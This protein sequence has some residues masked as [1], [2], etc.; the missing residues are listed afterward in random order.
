MW[1]LLRIPKHH[2]LGAETKPTIKEDALLSQ[3]GFSPGATRLSFVEPFPSCPPGVS[4]DGWPPP[5]RCTELARPA[6]TCEMPQNV[7]L[8]DSRLLHSNIL[9]AGNHIFMGT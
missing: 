5:W 2:P 4:E 8:L 7:D 1:G 6:G 9:L 3:Q